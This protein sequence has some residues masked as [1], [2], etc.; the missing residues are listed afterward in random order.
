MNGSRIPFGVSLLDE[1]LG[2]VS[3]GGLQVLTGGPGTGKTITALHFLQA[4][5]EQGTKV[6]LVTQAR[7]E[8]VLSLAES[9]GMAWVEPVRSGSAVIIGYRSGFRERYR[10]VVE[11]EAVFNELR[12]LLTGDGDPARIAIDTSGPLADS[13]D[14]GTGAELLVDMLE[15]LAATSLLTFTAEQPGALSGGIDFILQRSSLILHITQTSAGL[16][17]FHVR[18]ATGLLEPAGPITFDTRPGEGIAEPRTG[19]RRRATD[20]SPEIRRR[21]LLVDLAGRLPPEVRSWLD[22]S[23]ELSYTQDPL[24]AFPEVARR[25]FG[26]LVVNVDPGAVDQGL[27]VA[28][29]LRRASERAPLL[30]LCGSNVRASDRARALRLGADDFLS[31]DLNPDELASRIEALLRRGRAPGDSSLD[32]D[33]QPPAEASIHLDVYEFRDLVVTRL[34]KA[35]SPIFSIVLL[36]PPG[37]RDLGELRAH[38]AHVMRQN[39]EDRFTVMGDR[40]AVY[41]HGAL[42]PHIESFLRRVK[43]DGWQQIG[44]ETFTFPSDRGRLREVIDAR[45]G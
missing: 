25:E 9:I 6:G 39:G 7:P 30:I 43:V 14:T 24:E 40:L 32:G 10:R 38:L 11:P 15:E 2:G 29:Q 21:I 26:M 17:Q 31:G 34:A 19:V 42:A 18:K 37:D 16:R 45:D 8:D 23:F 33:G 35:V 13:R 5:L 20:L 36:R 22:E 44:V 41:L 3:R 12:A 4:G 28:H 1:R 27:H